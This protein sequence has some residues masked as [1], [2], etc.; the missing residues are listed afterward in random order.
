MESHIRFFD[1]LRYIQFA[2]ALCLSFYCQPVFNNTGDHESKSFNQT[3]ILQCFLERRCGDSIKN[4]SYTGS[5]YTFVQK[6]SITPLTP[7][8]T[9]EVVSC[10]SNPS[11][12]SGLSIDGQCKISGKP[13]ASQP[14]KS[15]T[16]IANSSDSS[17]IQANIEISVNSFQI[18]AALSSSLYAWYPLDGDINDRSGNAHHGYFPGGIWPATSGPS[19]ASG[20][21]NIP[22]DVA[23]FNGSNQLF[24]SDFAPLCHEDFAIALWVSAGVASNNKIMGYQQAPGS[25]PGI[26]FELDATGR[27][28]FKAFW[29]AS[30][31]NMD[32]ISGS[33]STVVSANVWTHIVYVHNGATRQGN[34]WVNGVNVG[35]TSNFGSF[36]GCTTGTSS[37]QWWAGAPLNIGYA[38]PVGFFTGR[39]DDIWFFRGRQLSA[40]DISTLMSLP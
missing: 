17:S 38:Y 24:G 20:R 14:K 27:V 19:Y 6:V 18:P 13:L 16:I 26:T 23:S 39:M 5:P 28:A 10:V 37:N 30:G 1:L 29:V 2:F 11:L 40:A 33:S 9:V 4:I 36:A 15:Y 34:V 35:A 7:S 21:S 25:N 8:L 22:S 3:K 12:P 31:N 32:G